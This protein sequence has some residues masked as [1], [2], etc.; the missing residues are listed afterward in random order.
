MQLAEDEEAPS[1]GGAGAKKH[2][3]FKKERGPSK[4][5]A[6]KPPSNAD[7]GKSTGRN[8]TC[9]LFKPQIEKMRSLGPKVKDPREMMETLKE[10]QAE[11]SQ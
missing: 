11:I 1:F 4:A 5:T 9:L 10:I 7:V 6:S 3:T 2:R 8:I